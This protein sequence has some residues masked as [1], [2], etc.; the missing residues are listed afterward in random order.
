MENKEIYCLQWDNKAG[1]ELKNHGLYTSKEEAFNSI[2]A[3]WDLNDFKPNYW[4]VWEKDEVTTVDYG[5]HYA[6]YRIKKV[7]KSNYGEIMFGGIGIE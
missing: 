6:F 1:K 5:L 3:W 4:R 2:L 7:D